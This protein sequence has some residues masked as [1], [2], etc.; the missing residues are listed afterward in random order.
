MTI[1]PA[2][3]PAKREKAERAWNSTLPRPQK[4]PS[5]PSSSPLKRGSKK[6]GSG[7]RGKPAL[8][9]KPLP[10]KRPVAK[11]NP[12]RRKKE[13]ARAY[14]SAE[15]VHFVQS[16]PCVACAELYAPEPCP[17][18]PKIDNAHIETDGVGRKAHYTKI[19]PLCNYLPDVPG[20]H[21]YLHAWGRKEFERITRVDLEA[22]AA[23]T[24]QAWQSYLKNGESK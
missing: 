22:A 19:V 15:R 3:K 7:G 9:R 10:R 16:L 8:R 5:S 14:H 6:K 24:E 21:P 12:S 4:L 2:P 18:A 1:R 20:H 17:P 11:R 23:R 13:F